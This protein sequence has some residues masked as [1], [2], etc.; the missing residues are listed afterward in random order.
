LSTEERAECVLDV[1]VKRNILLG[2]H[3]QTFGAYNGSFI[4]GSGVNSGCGVA[5]RASQPRV[6]VVRYMPAE[7]RLIWE[8]YAT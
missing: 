7:I 3:P 1:V 4:N 2:F 6:A 5:V 8:T